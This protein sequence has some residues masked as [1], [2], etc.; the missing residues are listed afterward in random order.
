[1]DKAMAIGEIEDL[2]KNWFTRTDHKFYNDSFIIYYLW[3]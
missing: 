3:F 1:M 2:P